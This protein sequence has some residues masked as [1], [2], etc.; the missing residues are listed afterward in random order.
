MNQKTKRRLPS[1]HDLAPLMQFKK[2]EFDATKRRLDKA[3]TIGDLRRIAK[4]RTPRAAFDYTDG[5][6]EA[7]LSIARARQAFLDIE[8]HPAILRDVSKVHTG[9]NVLGAP[10]SLPFGIAWF[11]I[12][13]TGLSVSAGLL[14]TFLGLPLLMLVVGFGRVIGVVE[15]AKARGL[16]AL[17]LPAFPPPAGAK[18][19]GSVSAR[20]AGAAG[21]RI[22]TSVIAPYSG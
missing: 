10:V 6:A 11:V 21:S 9:W 18:G 14:V 2:P 12:V 19:A 15:R 22:R 4:R 5:S 13:V 16:L 1:V 20:P 17:D 3:L 7:E 8:F